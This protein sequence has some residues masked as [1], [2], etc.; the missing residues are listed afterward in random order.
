MKRFIIKKQYIGR[1]LNARRIHGYFFPIR[2]VSKTMCSMS[3]SVVSVTL[4][5]IRLRTD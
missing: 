1:Y 2:F 5:L 4:N 3:P